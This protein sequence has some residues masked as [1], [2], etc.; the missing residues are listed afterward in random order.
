MNHDY[1]KKLL[2]KAIFGCTIIAQGSL[3][4]AEKDVPSSTEEKGQVW[5]TSGFLSHHFNRKPGYNENNTGIGIEYDFDKSR[6]IALGHYRNSVRRSSTYLHFI[7]TPLELGPFR[8][9]GAVGLLDGYPLLRKGR[10]T[11]VLV[12]AVMSDFKL[13][14]HGVGVNFMYIPTVTNRIDGAIALQFKLHVD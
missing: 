2:I 12:P 4:C 1:G 11:P 3:A 10:Y 8:A 6:A 5:L 7:Y 13:F 9:G 14:G